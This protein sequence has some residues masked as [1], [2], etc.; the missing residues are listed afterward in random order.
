MSVG[1][2]WNF[3]RVLLDRQDKSICVTHGKQLS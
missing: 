1:N 3:E 2:F